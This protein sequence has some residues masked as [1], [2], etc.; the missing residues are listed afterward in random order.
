MPTSA[1]SKNRCA[2]NGSPATHQTLWQQG[3]TG[4]DTQIHLADW[5]LTSLSV[6]MIKKKKSAL[7]V[8]VA[9]NPM[10]FLSELLIPIM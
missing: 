3:G 4:E 10:L 9:K 5:T 7:A 2:A 8:L 1:D 6:A